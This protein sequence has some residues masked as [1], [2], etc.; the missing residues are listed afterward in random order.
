MREQMPSKQKI[1]EYWFDKILKDKPNYIYDYNEISCF[2]CGRTNGIERSHLVAHI[3]G[4]DESIDNLHLLCRS[5]HF[6]TEGLYQIDPN[7]YYAY[8]RF[9]KSYDIEHYEI[10]KKMYDN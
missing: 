2:A 8:L 10:I 5:C 3:Y 4:G 9:K 7:H 6:S 1:W